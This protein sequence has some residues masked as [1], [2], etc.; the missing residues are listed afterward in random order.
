VAVTKK[1]E[2][3]REAAKASQKFKDNERVCYCTPSRR[4]VMSVRDVCLNQNMPEVAEEM[5][6]RIAVEMRR[7]T[8]REH[9]GES[10]A[11]FDTMDSQAA[12]AIWDSGDRKVRES[13]EG[14]ALTYEKEEIEEWDAA[15]AAWEESVRAAAKPRVRQKAAPSLDPAQK[16]TKAK[17]AA[18]KVTQNA[19]QGR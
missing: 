9:F 7:V 15:K 17:K 13:F 3:V 12:Y 11:D 6:D 1:S 2:M 8:G 14:A 16:R 5:C 10:L 19:E 4:M 18:V